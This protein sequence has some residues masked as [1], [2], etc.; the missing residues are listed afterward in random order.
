MTGRIIKGIA[1]FYYV[2]IAGSGIYECK[3]KGLF[4]KLGIKP[5]VGDIVDIE[6]THEADMEANIVKIRKRKN[7]LYRPAVANIDQMIFVTALKEPDPNLRVVDRFLI[8]MKRQDI[9]VVICFNKLDIADGSFADELKE[10]YT[11]AGYETILCSSFDQEDIDN[12]KKILSGKTSVFSGPSGVGKSSIVNA[13]APEACMET[14]EIS[15]KLHKGRHTTR[16]SELFAVSEG[17]YICDT[18]G[19]TSF[20]PEDM[21]KEDL[22]FCFDEFSPYEGRCRFSGCVHADE[23]DCEV[24]AAV[25]EGKISKV[26][27]ESYISFYNELKE[28]EKNRY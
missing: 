7:E 6:I 14:G 9:K 17:T 10:I 21:E 27:Y 13:I 1:G 22:R 20:I 24:K 8:Q 26:R 16:H 19:F 25:A 2:D 3:A 4:R 15:R 11:N 18:P 12:I 28:R 5:L 23:P